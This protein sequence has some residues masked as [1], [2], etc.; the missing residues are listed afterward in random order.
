MEQSQAAGPAHEVL[1]FYS[2]PGP[3][4]RAGDQEA[5]FAALPAEVEAL[6]RVVQ[7]L[8]LHEF[9]ASV[10]HGVEIA[11]ERQFESHIRAVPDMLDR[12]RTS[13]VGR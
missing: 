1:A 10:M 7:G 6:A 2:S 4:T 8:V 9:T 3:V 5:A 12:L 13:A 11:P